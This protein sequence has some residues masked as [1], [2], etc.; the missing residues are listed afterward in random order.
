M[1]DPILFSVPTTK[2]ARTLSGKAYGIRLAGSRG[3]NT[4]M[5]LGYSL[6]TNI[7]IPLYPTLLVIFMKFLFISNLD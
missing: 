1:Q 7:D 3:L 5:I 6:P 4:I 2:V